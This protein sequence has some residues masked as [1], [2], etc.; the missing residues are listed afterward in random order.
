MSDRNGGAAVRDFFFLAVAVCLHG[1]LF[2]ADPG[3]RWGASAARE[4]VI[5]VE[6]VQA[7]T[8]PFLAPIPPG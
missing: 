6:F 4:R 7:P 3:L 8:S 2:A 5:P 1:A